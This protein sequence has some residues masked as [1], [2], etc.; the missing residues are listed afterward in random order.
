MAL[1]PVHGATAR[2]ADIRRELRAASPTERAARLRELAYSIRRSDLEMISRA[3]QGHIGG[4]YSAADI[5]TV[6]YFAVLD[7]RPEE[8]EWA[9][10]DRFVLSKGHAAGILYSTLAHAGFFPEAELATFM[11]PLSPLNGHPNRRKV[12]GV[13]TNTGPLGHGFPVAV[14]MAVAARLDGSGRRTYVVT[15]DGELQEG[16]NWEAAMSASQQRLGRLTVI[17][18]RNRFQQGAATEETSGLDPLDAKWASFGF[19]V[20]T[21]DGHDHEALHQALSEE[22]A[23]DD[24]PRCLIADTVKGKGVSFIENRVEWHHKVPTTD[25][26]AAALKE[27]TSR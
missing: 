18:D 7:V 6:L 20:R 16:S 27:L 23:V 25:Q 15:G 2:L 10:R 14:G 24:R 17:V 22:R 4:D 13:E 26:T 5:V 9:E 12:P 3:G 19:D 11:E 1:A 21:V 8:P